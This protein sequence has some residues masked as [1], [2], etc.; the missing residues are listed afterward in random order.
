MTDLKGKY[1][2]E[3]NYPGDGRLFLNYWDF[4]HGED[5]CVEYKNETLYTEEQ[6]EISLPDFLKRVEESIKQIDI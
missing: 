1:E 5:V 2:L 3:L 6:E 4:S